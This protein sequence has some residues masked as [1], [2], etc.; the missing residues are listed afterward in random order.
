MLCCN[1]VLI[2]PTEIAWGFG[3]ME[4][5]GLKKMNSEKNKKKLHYDD[6]HRENPI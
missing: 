2:S 4:S 3:G 6:T 1:D 5:K